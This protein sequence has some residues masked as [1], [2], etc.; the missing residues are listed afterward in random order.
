MASPVGTRSPGW[1]QAI[2]EQIKQRRCIYWLAVPETMTDT[3]RGR[4]IVGWKEYA[5]FPEWAVRRVK[6]K[7][8][9]GART[10]AL[11]VGFGAGLLVSLFGSWQLREIRRRRHG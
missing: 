8:D 9:T 1:L 2:E 7:I 5:D 4:L 6:V 3:E 10:S 11:G